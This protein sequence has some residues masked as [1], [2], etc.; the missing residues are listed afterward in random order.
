[1]VIKM[2]KHLEFMYDKNL[3]LNNFVIYLKGTTIESWCTKVYRTAEGRNCLYGHLA[4]FV[5]NE[6]CSDAIDIF[7][8][9]Y[10]TTYMIFPVNDGTSDI[11]KQ[12]NPRDRC[13]AYLENMII[14]KEHT[15]IE[16][17]D[18]CMAEWNS[19]QNN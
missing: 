8:N 16:L 15:T 13:I 7:E 19:K 11:Y 2:T 6:Y 18:I 10:A 3:F 1:M 4:D 9:L 5:G 14:G 12:D 17:F